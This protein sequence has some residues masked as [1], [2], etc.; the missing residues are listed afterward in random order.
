MKNSPTFFFNH[1]HG[2]LLSNLQD[3]HTFNNE[4]RVLATT[5]LKDEQEIL[6]MVEHKRYP[7]FGVQFHPEKTIYEHDENL[8]L[9][10]TKMSFQVTNKLG[11]YI[12]HMIKMNKR[13]KD[14]YLENDSVL[15]MRRF[16]ISQLDHKYVDEVYQW[17][18]EDY[19]DKIQQIINEIKLKYLENDH[20]KL[21]EDKK[22][23]D[24][25]YVIGNKFLDAFSRI[26]LKPNK[27][28]GFNDDNI[29]KII[30]NK[31]GYDI[32]ITEVHLD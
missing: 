30:R 18:Y 11:Q 32:K 26:S 3:S 14:V 15:D 2:F 5:I 27:I 22:L 12:L 23:K 16:E 19:L 8:N 7:W 29:D 25:R 24:G 9:K 6:S 21:L 20:Q 10:K 13:N 17:N 28:K 1:N 4:F 31:Y